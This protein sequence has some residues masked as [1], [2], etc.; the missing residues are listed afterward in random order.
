VETSA[1]AP[2]SKLAA[3]VFTDI[4]GYSGIVHRDEALGAQVLETQREVVRR[5]VREHGGVEVETAGDSFLLEFGSALGAVDAVIAIQQ[6]LARVAGRHA[7]VLRAG[8]HLGEVEHRGREIY[9]DGV[10]VTARL[11]PHSPEGGLALSAAVATV[12]RQRRS[13]PLK[14]IGQ[15]A[16][17]NIATPVEIFVLDSRAIQS[18]GGVRA[19]GVAAFRSGPHGV[20]IA[21][22]A[23]ALAALID[24]S[25]GAALLVL[26][27]VFGGKDPG[28]YLSAVY[29]GVGANVLAVAMFWNC[30]GLAR[31]E[32]AARHRALVLNA[33]NILA[34]TALL[35]ML[36]DL[37]EAYGAPVKVRLW[38]Q[39]V[40]PGLSLLVAGYLMHPSV[41]GRFTRA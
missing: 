35:A 19:A 34:A 3:I 31:L 9:G 11:L 4:V 8:I 18:L 5:I 37:A 12:I 1:A 40:G 41:G 6:A 17:K 22:L 33:L 27:H 28:A 24:L 23:Q 39:L 2:A 38:S 10:N 14:S 29:A 21:V 16:L 32:K 30:W 26:P 20:L 36:T 13:L 7:V 15:P 25:L